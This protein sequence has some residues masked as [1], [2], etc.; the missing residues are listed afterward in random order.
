LEFL[1]LQSHEKEK[2]ERKK[3][4]TK[5]RMYYCDEDEIISHIE[6]ENEAE[7]PSEIVKGLYLGGIESAENL[8]ALKKRG[9]THILN[10]CGSK[11][12]YPLEFEYLVFQE[13]TDCPYQDL[14]SYFP[15]CLKFIQT[16]IDNGGTI[17]VHCRAGVSRSAAIVCAYLMWSHKLTVTDAITIVTRARPCV[18]P[19]AGFKRQL[20]LWKALNYECIEDSPILRHHKLFLL[21]KQFAET[22]MVKNLQGATLTTSDLNRPAFV[23]QSC[24]YKLFETDHLFSDL[25]FQSLNYMPLGSSSY[26]IFRPLGHPEC[27]SA[28]QVSAP[29]DYELMRE[30][31]VGLSTSCPDPRLERCE[32]HFIEPM[33]WMPLDIISKTHSGELFCPSCH[34]SIGYWSWTNSPCDCHRNLAPTFSILKTSVLLYQ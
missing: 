26:T 1:E 19:N 12:L 32:Y 6:E 17:L 24:H 18:S 4:S 28:S 11:V 9:I 34:L 22:K 3:G 7:V 33:V 31:D 10:L 20:F 27:E 30:S 23:C 5:G 25:I 15:P 16:A 8:K 2:N 21:S 29:S 14:L 13:I